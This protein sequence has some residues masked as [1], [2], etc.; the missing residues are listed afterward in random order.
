MNL[1]FDLGGVV[2]RWDPDAIIAGVFQDE[3]TRARV[4]EGVFSHP[5]WLEL[6]R[7]EQVIGVLVG[8]SVIRDNLGL[9]LLC[10]GGSFL[11]A[12]TFGRLGTTLAATSGGSIA[13]LLRGLASDPWFS[14]RAALGLALMAAA[15][16]VTLGAERRAWQRLMTA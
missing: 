5:D 4:R 12:A 6:D 8:A 10:L 7:G 2:V 14:T 3:A 1:V 11:V 13:T 15:A 9:T 16:V